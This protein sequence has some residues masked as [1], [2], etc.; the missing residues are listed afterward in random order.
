[1]SIVRVHS[2]REINLLAP[3]PANISIRDIAVQLSRIARFN[4]ATAIPYYVAQHSV[5][6]AAI[7]STLG[8]SP[9]EQFLAL[10]HDAHEA[11][12]G[13]VTRPVL[14]ALADA[15]DVKFADLR[16]RMDKAIFWTFGIRFE[17]M[18]EVVRTADEIA[19]ATEWRDLMPGHCPSS[20]RP[21]GTPVKPLRHDMA[22]QQFLK[23]FDRL[24]LAAG[25]C[26]NSADRH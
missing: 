24:L 18:P 4:G 6:V 11:F 17:G 25:L 3:D 1:M 5:F 2:G 7:A 8:A 21:V 15:G 12:I 19:L 22:E 13:D 14:R 16:W 9:R 10:M 26:S 20:F 23:T